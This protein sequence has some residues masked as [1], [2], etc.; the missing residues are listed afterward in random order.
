MG[1]VGGSI[2]RRVAAFA[3]LLAA[4]VGQAADR[5]PGDLAAQAQVL[6]QEVRSETQ[7][8]NRAASEPNQNQAQLRAFAERRER[9]MLALMQASPEAALQE[10]FDPAARKRM[11]EEVR[12]HIEEP[13]SRTGTLE[14]LGVLAE[15]GRAGLERHLVASGEDLR[16]AIDLPEEY[17]T[18]T[19]LTV[20][21]LLLGNWLA[22]AMEDVTIDAAV[23]APETNTSLTTRR[24]LIISINFSDAPA[25]P[26]SMDLARQRFD[27]ISDWYLETSY[28]QM[29][30]VS[31]ILGWFTIDA[32]STSCATTTFR[33]QAE[34][35][36]RGAGYE[37]NDYDHIVI[38]FPRVASCGWA[39]L[40]QVPGRYVWLNNTINRAPAVHELGHNLGLLHSH[41]RRCSD[42]P[43]RGSCSTMEYG[44]IFDA[45]GSGGAEYHGSFRRYLG[46]IA[47]SDVLSISALDGDLTAVLRSSETDYGTRVLQVQRATGDYLFIEAR[48]AIGFDSLLTQY[49][50]ALNGITVYAGP[51]FRSQSLVDIGFTTTTRTDAP[52]QFGETLADVDGDVGI[53][54]L[55]NL[56][57]EFYVQ[58]LFGLSRP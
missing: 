38:A 55:Y 7:S 46:W 26:W 53:T 35:A 25:E 28:G 47:S 43:L 18:G 1:F 54:P 19:R 12:K 49:P 51:S 13:A 15:D 22:G 9:A 40:A 27:N 34:A 20:R 36:A 8:L 56:G 45:M 31:D 50:A 48:E 32:P 10:A 58:V 4:G 57:G 21:G 16:L 6:R 2:L 30:I 17:V 14:L 3:T 11:P 44:D 5:P 41:S 23:T 52:L 42:D 33:N 39:G 37:P 24:A 29:T